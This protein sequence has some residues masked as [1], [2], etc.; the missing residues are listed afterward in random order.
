M[1]WLTK[2]EATCSVKEF[3]PLDQ[4]VKFVILTCEN[5]KYHLLKLALTASVRIS[6]VVPRPGTLDKLTVY[7]VRSGKLV[8]ERQNNRTFPRLGQSNTNMAIFHRSVLL[9]LC[10]GCTHEACSDFA[11]SVAELVQYLPDCR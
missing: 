9:L 10:T 11:F 8:E 3:G 5:V 1:H 6:I 7:L 4:K 2:R